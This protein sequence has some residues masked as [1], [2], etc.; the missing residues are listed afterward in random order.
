[1]SQ[2]QFDFDKAVAGLKQNRPAHVPNLD[3]MS[4][5]DR[6]RRSPWVIRAVVVTTCSAVGIGILIPRSTAGA[7]WAQVAEKFAKQPRVHILEKSVNLHS[8]RLQ[9]ESESWVDGVKYS[10]S[11]KWGERTSLAVCDGKRG[12]SYRNFTDPKNGAGRVAWIAKIKSPAPPSFTSPIGMDSNSIDE[13]IKTADV[14]VLSQETVQGPNGKQ[15]RYKIERNPG[16]KTNWTYFV[17]ADSDTGLIRK[18][19]H[20]IS[21]KA[22]REATI[23]YPADVDPKVF[24][25]D[26][27]GYATRDFD[28]MRS[29]VTN[30]IKQGL[31]S[32]TVTGKT[33]TVRSVLYSED[34]GL[35]VLWTGSTP[36]G[37][38]RHPI[39]LVGFPKPVKAQYSYPAKNVNMNLFSIKAFTVSA[40]LSSRAKLSPVINQRIGGMAVGLMN[41]KFSKIN[42]IIPVVDETGTKKLGSARFNNLP[43]RRIDSIYS[44]GDLLGER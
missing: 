39:Q 33:I 2:N 42:V 1:M 30:D 26:G 12:L 17:T 32:K 5:L 15:V 10:Y 23:D 8:G 20:F 6:S 43:V 19:E 28:E 14:K 9:V 34:G 7:A 24:Q 44:Y 21:G 25:V 18:V 3:S 16:P 40:G 35:W 31:G 11:T 13:V 36:S 38:L 4:N 27:L 41:Q 29:V 22:I 37:D